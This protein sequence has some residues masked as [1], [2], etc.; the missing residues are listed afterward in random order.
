ME[1]QLFRHAPK[2]C[3]LLS[4]RARF[5]QQLPIGLLSKSGYDDTEKLKQHRRMSG[6]NWAEVNLYRKIGWKKVASHRVFVQV[7]RHKN[8][9]SIFE[10]SPDLRRSSFCDGSA[11][12]SILFLSVQGLLTLLPSRQLPR[13][14]TSSSSARAKA[15]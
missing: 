10:H 9:L 5:S 7:F 14:Y 3:L 1:P 2:F 6:V 8:D 13:R 12:R 11:D 15:A 4:R